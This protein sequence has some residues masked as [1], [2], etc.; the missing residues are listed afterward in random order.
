V[1]AVARADGLVTAV[2]DDALAGAVEQALGH[3]DPV[4]LER[5]SSRYST[6]APIEDVVVH[7]ADGSSRRLVLK[8]LSA[9]SLLP[10]AKAG[11]PAFLS[12]PGREPAVYRWLLPEVPADRS[13]GCLHIG[14]G[15]RTTWLLL[16]KV[17]GVELYQVG[18]L[19]VW[20]G[21]AAAV[22]RLHGELWSALDHHPQVRPHLVVHDEPAM[23]D[24]MRRARVFDALHGGVHYADLVALD[25]VHA[26]VVR[27]LV[28]QPPVV[29]HGDLYASNVLVVRDDLLRVC[30]IDWEYA[31]GGAGVPRRRGADQWRLEPEG[32]GGDVAGLLGAARRPPLVS[33]LGRVGSMP[34]HGATAGVRPVARVVRAVGS[35]G[36]A[37][38]GLAG[39]G[40]PGRRPARRTRR[41]VTE[42][43][44][45]IVNADD[46]GLSDSV[47]AGIARTHEEGIVTAATLM[48]RGRA[49]Q[50]AADYARRTP[51]L[52]VGLHVD[53]AEWE[54]RDGE[55][56]ARYTVVDSADEDAVR[57]EVDRQLTRFRDLLGRDPAH[58]D[59][60]QH[61]HRERP[62][63]GVLRRVGERL[64]VPVRHQSDDI[65]YRGDF[66]GQTGKGE[67]YPVAITVE[68]LV[69]VL[70]T[71]PAGTTELGCH[72]GLA[73]PQLDNVYRD[74][75]PVEVEVLCDPRVRAAVDEAGIR[76]VSFDEAAR[77]ST[78]GHE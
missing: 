14:E 10:G 39:R 15:S 6:S 25:R 41:T 28:R 33:Q 27:E 12:D 11:K 23:R 51:S 56:I 61:V 69:E 20:C 63:A 47:N 76:L 9:A 29:L 73:D 77:S 13:A 46:F 43:R 55:W 70:R 42:E 52:S 75:R 54:Y 5:A 35:A 58:L 24:W 7:L 59:S 53:L 17:A 40:P 2:P 49:A 64:G 18:E 16:E 4:R 60:H 1:I 50:A 44:Y 21:A 26:R 67:P 36:R 45:L 48:V 78:G 57:D 32:A 66:Y 68:A 31:G 34:G 22:A 74:E 19:E 72:R 37:H 65:T 8:D 71:L 38:P 30:P 3:L 62:V